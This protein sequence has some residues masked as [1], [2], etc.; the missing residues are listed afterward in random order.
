MTKRG[1]SDVLTFALL[2]GMIFIVTALS[3][4]EII[5]PKFQQ[6]K[7]DIKAKGAS[8]LG[9]EYNSTTKLL[10]IKGIDGKFNL[11]EITLYITKKDTNI[12]I[13]VKHFNYDWVWNYTINVSQEFSDCISAIQN[14]LVCVRYYSISKCFFA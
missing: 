14:P 9:I 7:N 1:S 10:T 8:T 11:E 3:V 6:L 5:I 4:N 13:C 2:I 12:P